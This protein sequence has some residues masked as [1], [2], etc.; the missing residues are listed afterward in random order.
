MA[1]ISNKIVTLNTGN[2]MSE[3]NITDCSTPK[4][5][6]NTTKTNKG[7]VL[8]FQP[9]SLAFSHVN[10]YIN[11]PPVCISIPPYC[12]FNNLESYHHVTETYTTWFIPGNEERGN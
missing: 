10:Y 1:T 7:M 12:F 8:P 5:A 4:S 11:M 9:L 3:R 2:N 6:N